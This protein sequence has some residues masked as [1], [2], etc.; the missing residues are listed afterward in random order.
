MFVSFCLL[1]MHSPLPADDLYA[2][3]NGWQWLEG[4]LTFRPALASVF[5]PRVGFIFYGDRNNIRLDIG[6]GIDFLSRDFQDG[7]LSIGAE[8]LTF[9]L[10]ES[11]ENMH[12]PVITTDYFFGINL[13]YNRPIRNGLFAGRF[14]FTHISTHFVDGHFDTDEGVWRD[15]REPIIYSREFI[16][17]LASYRRNGSFIHRWYAGPQ[18]IFNITPD[19]L[20][21]FAFQGG[22]E[23]FFPI[24]IE[25][26]TPYVAYD[27]RLVEI[28]GWNANHS[29]QTGLKFGHRFGR[30]I[31]IFL[32]YYNGFSVH[33]QLFDEKIEYWGFGFNV[34]I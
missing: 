21:Q 9:T 15:G 12:F 33:G 31:D 2:G 30:G 5:E 1:L 32:S 24:E 17:F 16:E 4:G 27:L 10:L 26:I 11:W 18:F 22:Y 34:T 25:Y 3:E 13:S 6:S 23:L 19:Q 29:I 14:R 7:T 28:G 8:F 20:G